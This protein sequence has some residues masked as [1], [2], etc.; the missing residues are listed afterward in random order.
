[1]QNH[2]K[3]AHERYTFQFG[4]T[5]GKLATSLDI[6]TDALS[7]IGQHGVYCRSTADPRQP[8]RDVRLVLEQIEDAKGLIITAMR[9]LRAPK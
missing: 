6:L 2:Y 7:L 5:S 8:S 3:E 9:E 1:M 4:P